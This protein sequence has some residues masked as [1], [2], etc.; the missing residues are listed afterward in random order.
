[1]SFQ[2]VVVAGGGVL[3]SQI[4]MVT[5]YHGFD[6]TF[7][8]RM[9]SSISRTKPKVDQIYAAMKSDVNAAAK[10]GSYPRALVLNHDP[11]VTD[12]NTKNILAKIDVA[13]QSLTYELDM[14]AA[15]KD[16]DLIIETMTEDPK[17]KI[18]FYQKAAPLIEEKTILVT[19]SSTMVPSTF[20]QYTG[21][22]QKYL[23]LHYANS[24][25]KNNSAEIM[26]HAGTSKE[27]YDAVVEFAKECGMIPLLLKKEQPGYL[28]NSVLVPFLIAGMTLVANDVADPENVDMAWKLGT[29]AP[30]G[31]LQIVDVVGLKTAYDIVKML[32]G[33]DDATTNYGKI[34][35]MLKDHLD[36]GKGG[37]AFGEGFYKYK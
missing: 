2:K 13:Y 15:F 31:P 12:E 17:A 29:G 25:W 36:Q 27:A 5:A 24:I 8:L 7:W 26:G 23:A 19:N 33:A 30:H 16:A 14:A 9:E 21:R 6:V 35:A 22:P 18:A 10:T 34:A 28:L 32:P 3:G 37:L 1:M 11:N 4:A 20:A